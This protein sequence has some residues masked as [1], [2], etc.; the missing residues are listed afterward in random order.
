VVEKLIFDQSRPGVRGAI[1]PELDIPAKGV[2]SL[3]PVA[4]RRTDTP[5]LPEVSEPEVVRHFTNLSTLNHHVDKD[6]YPL[7][8]CTMK[9]NPKINDRLAALPGLALIHPLAPDEEVQGALELLKTLECA[10]AEITGL[11]AVTLQ[12][13]AGAEGELTAMLVARAYHKSR[14]E[15]RDEVIIPDSA[16][17]TN[18]A[19]VRIAGMKAVEI[20]SNAEGKVDLEALRKVLGPRTAAMMVTN[21]NTLGIFET[22]IEE[23]AA[24]VHGAGGLLYLDGANMNALVGL[25][26]PGEM[27]FDMMHLNLHKTFSTPHGGGGPG[28]GPIAVRE[29]LRPFLPVPVIEE[30]N[31]VYHVDYDRPLSV[32]RM[33]GFHGN[34]GILV[35]ALVYI[36]SLGGTGLTAMTRNAILNANYLLAALRGDYFV[37]YPGP[38]MH[39]FVLSAV[40]QKKHGVRAGDVS[41]RLLDFGMHAPTTYFPL[42][43]EEALMIEP[44]ESEPKPTLDRFIEIMRRIAREAA[45]TPDLVKGAPHTT[46]V[47]RPD[48]ALAARQL[49]LRWSPGESG[50]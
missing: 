28:A 9:Y 1:F 8:S 44:T 39:E 24:A 46:P 30:K 5:L 38:C 15:N 18:P 26:R 45:E 43:V 32:G 7:G 22:H 11:P 27:G 25:V 33:H 50:S 20:K 19:S 47:A 17:G 12:P 4:L 16:H 23:I 13:A 37:K 6:F 41:K 35:R 36:M 29:D 21:P 10:L 49:K 42:I 48:E 3:V 34:F 31:G 2:E 14:G 40:E